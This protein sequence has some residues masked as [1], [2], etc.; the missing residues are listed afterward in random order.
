MKWE[1]VEWA[2]N[3]VLNGQGFFISY[4]RT[5]MSFENNNGETALVVDGGYYI[6][7]GDHRK[8]YEKRIKDLGECV[9]Y[10]QEH[11]EDISFWSNDNVEKAYK[12]QII[13]NLAGVK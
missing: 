9:K 3:E 5:P 6:L 11:K 4:N 8:E 12:N 13:L 1:K 7:N 2:G 10:F